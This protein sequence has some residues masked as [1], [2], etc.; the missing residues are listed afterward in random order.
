MIRAFA[1]VMALALLAGPTLA[2]PQPSDELLFHSCWG[3]PRADLTLL[4]EDMPL[5]DPPQE[6]GRLIVTGAYT[7]RRP[8]EDGRPKPVGFF[9]RDG[10]VIN[11][12]MTRMDG[13]ALIDPKTGA[14][15]IHDRS[16]APLG[17]RVYNLRRVEPRAAFIEAAE[18]RGL[19]ALQSH[20]L[21]ID[22]APDVTDLAEA[23]RFRRRVLFTD[24]HGYGVYQSTGAETLFDAAERVHELFAPKMAM[25]LDMGSYD[26]CLMA[27]DGVERR[28]GVLSRDQTEKL[29][30]LLILSIGEN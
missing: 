5:P 29:S 19:S 15:A 26:F 9:M 8:R 16:A 6:A 18:D 3:E 14:L 20:L 2:C 21:V 4:P 13:L 7:G 27:E 23:P 17:D 24:D 1:A 25:N 28:C 10:E 12:N 11:R 22:G 30:N